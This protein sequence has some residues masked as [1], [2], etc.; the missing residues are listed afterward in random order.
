MLH[1][2]NTP[3]NQ[4]AKDAE[5]LEVGED[6]YMAVANRFFELLSSFF[7]AA[8]SFLRSTF[9][10]LPPPPA[11]FLLVRPWP[12]CTKHASLPLRYCSLSPAVLHPSHSQ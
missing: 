7:N 11:K 5:M 3:C 12:A 6:R 2:R 4:G 1:L 9:S 10:S 8:I